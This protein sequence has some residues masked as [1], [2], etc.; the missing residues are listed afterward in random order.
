MQSSSAITP[1]LL[2]CFPIRTDIEILQER[3][4]GISS[5]CYQFD[6]KAPLS[7]LHERPAGD[8]SKPDLI[9]IQS[10]PVLLAKQMLLFATALRYVPPTE[11]I[12]GLSKHHHQIMEEL[13]KAAIS[14][15]TTNDS[16]L[17]SLEGLENIILE[18]FYHTDSGDIRQAWVTLR[19][20][21]MAA[22]LLGLHRRGHYR[23]KIIGDRHDIDPETIWSSIVYMERV[24]S[25][26]SGLPTST[27]NMALARQEDEVNATDDSSLLTNLGNVAGKIL[28]RNQI[29]L[30]QQALN[31]TK[32]I[33]DELLRVAENLSP[34]FWRPP[35]FSGLTQDSLQAFNEIRRVF[36]HSSY[37]TLIIQLHMPHM[38]C[39]SHTTQ[40]MY[41][42]MAC[43]NASREILTRQIALRSFN[44]VTAC[45]RMNDFMA[46][47]AGMTLMLAHATS[48]CHN[49]EGNVL[50][51]QRL[52][53]RA[54]VQRALDCMTFISELQKDQLAVRC[55][56]MLK[57]LLVIE[58]GAA[59]KQSQDGAETEDGSDMLIIG[60]PFFSGMRISRGGIA[61]VTPSRNQNQGLSGAI[62]IGGIGSIRVNTP[63][64][65]NLT[66][67]DNASCPRVS[68]SLQQQQHD[69]LMQPDQNLSDITFDDWSVLGM[70]TAFF[71]SLM[72][73]SENISL[74]LS[75]T[76]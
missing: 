73:G 38:L 47:I 15:V 42:K 40:R 5:T 12:P 17:G 7:T 22:Q 4:N 24:V 6:Y 39:P 71:E 9:S 21:V 60:A 57:D 50:A 54:M 2:R 32:S 74:N 8:P 64:S 31:I 20:A 10:N 33:D 61:A 28:Q 59:R 25:L 23:Y 55:A 3:V 56:S 49:S 41:S 51:H 69:S 16:L 70:D 67:A 11:Q 76:N 26:L 44:L 75:N 35:E 29:E 43:V 72:Q 66:T 30:P 1:E 62:N 34:T 68:E 65:S 48:H 45:C 18:A 46:L 63:S 13:A 52:G 37:Y 27:D 36:D 19:R 58:E 53:D 14:K